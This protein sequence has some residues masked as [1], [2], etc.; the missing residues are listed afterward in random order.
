MICNSK[1]SLFKQSK[2]HVTT[3]RT[4]SVSIFNK[5]VYN[6]P[7]LDDDPSD[8]SVKYVSLDLSSVEADSLPP[9]PPPP[10]TIRIMEI[11]DTH[12]QS[13]S[14]LLHHP[15]PNPS[16]LVTLESSLI[17]S[18]P[19]TTSNTAVNAVVSSS[20]ASGSVYPSTCI[21]TGGKK[22]PFYSCV[23]MLSVQKTYVLDL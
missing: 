3:Q 20:S 6:L 13:A 12:P 23:I 15:P 7:G 19:V 5:T 21:T 17:M 14:D 11:I 10:T 9:P 18:G 1:N 2:I 22:I 16:A 8:N 4:Y